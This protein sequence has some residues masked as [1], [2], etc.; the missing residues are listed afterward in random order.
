M[1][2]RILVVDDEE[3]MRYL[4]KRYLESKGMTV[5]SVGDGA[6]ALAVLRA[7]RFD[8]VLLDLGLPKVGGFEVLRTLRREGPNRSAAVYLMSGLDAAGE[9]AVE[10]GIAVAGTFE[11]PFSLAAVWAAIAGPCGAAVPVAD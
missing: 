2:T 6:Q 7:E 5:T 10:G 4:L 8:L 1:S 11:K 3:G 9:A